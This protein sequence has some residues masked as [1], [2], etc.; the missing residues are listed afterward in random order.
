MKTKNPI[1]SARGLVKTYNQGKANVVHALCGV[2]FEAYRGEFVALVGP[3]GSGKSTLMHLLGLLQTPSKGE[4][5]IDGENMKRL[6][7]RLYPRVRAQKIG[8]VFQGFN[9]INTLNAKENV[10]LSA[11]YAGESARRAKEKAEKILR[12]VGLADRMTHRPN[13]LSGGQQQ[14]VAIARALVNEP[15]VVLADEPT[16]ELD[17]KNSDEIVKILK[18]LSRNGQTIVIVTHNLDVA[19][20][21]DRI[22]TMRDGNIIGEG[23]EIK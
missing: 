12:S 6:P 15:A 5:I 7:K 22:I 21:A 8:F 19:K 16:G 14:R 17:S 23:S 18:D 10:I 20:K 9:L 11:R 1:I 3:S 13:E 4:I 2:D